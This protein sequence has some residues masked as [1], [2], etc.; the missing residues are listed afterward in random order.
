MGFWSLLK[1]KLHSR[2]IVATSLPHTWEQFERVYDGGCSDFVKSLSRLYNVTE[3]EELWNK[4]APLAN[5]ID[6]NLKEYASFGAV[7]MDELTLDNLSE[8]AC[9]DVVILMLHHSDSMDEL[10]LSAGMVATRQFVLALPTDYSGVIDLSSC[11][12]SNIQLSVKMHCPRS[13]VLAVKS[14]T[15]VE[16]RLAIYAYVINLM[17]RRKKVLYINALEQ[18]LKIVYSTRSG[19]N[20]S[21]SEIVYLGG[22]A[23][24]SI[25]APKEVAR[26]NSFMI[27]VALH[28]GSDAEMVEL[29]AKEADGDAVLCNPG[30]LKM[31]LR[32]NDKIDLLLNIGASSS[33]DFKIK[34]KRQTVIWMN[35][36]IFNIAFVVDVAR[37]CKS[38]HFIVDVKVSV[39]K[40][41]VGNIVFKT[42]IS[43]L[44]SK[45]QAEFAFNQRSIDQEIRNAKME[46]LAS[47]SR[48]KTLLETALSQEETAERKKNLERDL[49]VCQNSIRLLN[50]GQTTENPIKRVFISST[51]D[52]H[53][54]RQVLREQ[55]ECCSMFPE[56]YENWPQKDKYPRDYCCE[57][58]LASDIFV[59]ILGP[60]YGFV[61]PMMGISM[62]EIEYRVAVQAG[63][64]ILVYII[65][66]HG[67]MLASE[68]ENED[69][70][71]K[72]IK[73][74]EINRMVEYF[75]DEM[76]LA[77]Y[78]RSD[79]K[80]LQLIN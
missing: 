72:L 3:K 77:L 9:A 42:K 79:L 61:E 29:Y 45:Q 75:E 63:K 18:A 80:T 78:A 68:P 37:N 46:L 19:I 27:Q 58:V 50:V 64:P 62:T 26:G 74:L 7:V 43:D 44:E 6:L 52:L 60:K 36:S 2:I 34:K 12:S 10:E 20:N 32:K 1:K 25:F 33:E 39:N 21:D 13:T 67:K 15:P 76:S 23:Q 70:Q 24:S 65:Q 31:R 30:R 41:V 11:Y 16:L 17:R 53:N 51:S 22:E 69:R 56:M 48:E 5:K 49:A 14:R 8:I 73:E 57:K 40:S 55:V 66:N 4:Y 47:L 54:Y 38:S 59:C 35:E 71:Q 28:K